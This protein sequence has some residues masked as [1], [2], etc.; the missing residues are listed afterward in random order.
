MPLQAEGPP[1]QGSYLVL[2]I[3]RWPAFLQYMHV[4]KPHHTRPANRPTVVKIIDAAGW[5]EG[6]VGRD[7]RNLAN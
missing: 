2:T 6:V 4:P 3:A 1:F 5:T 7:I